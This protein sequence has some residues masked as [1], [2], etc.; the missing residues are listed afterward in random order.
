M[1]FAPSLLSATP[2]NTILGKQKVHSSG[3]G[4]SHHTS[5]LSSSLVPQRKLVCYCM[6]NNT[7]VRYNKLHIMLFFKDNGIKLWGNVYNTKN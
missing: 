5:S 7:V 2:G 3:S 6:C 1:V 4:G